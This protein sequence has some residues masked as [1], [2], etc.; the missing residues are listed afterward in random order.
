[1][2]RFG[3]RR[4]LRRHGPALALWPASE[5]QAALRLLG[6]SAR[7]RATLAAALAAA[8]EPH[9]ADAALLARLRAGLA[10][11]IDAAAP[12]QPAARPVANVTPRAA[13]G[14]GFGAALRWGAVA[15]CFGLGLW[16]GTAAL[17]PASA[18]PDLLAYLQTGAPGA[19][20]P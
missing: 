12:P 20:L 16:L 2:T 10:A 6:R 8:P 1:M 7:A 9:A 18:A 19:E 15:A 3:L 4:A 5:R 17:A 14:W 13:P 11:R